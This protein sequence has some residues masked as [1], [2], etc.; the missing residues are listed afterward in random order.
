MK[1]LLIIIVILLLSQTSFGQRN[2]SSNEYKYPCLVKLVEGG[3]NI[4]RIGFMRKN[5]FF[6]IAEDISLPQASVARFLK[7]VDLTDKYFV[8]FP[9]SADT[10]EM[11]IISKNCVTK[12]DMTFEQAIEVIAPY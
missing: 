7:D 4:F 2:K 5:D 10:G 12:L 9:T 11:L 3:S 8:Y 6:D 1:K